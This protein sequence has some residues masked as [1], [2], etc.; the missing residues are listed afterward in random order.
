MI[1]EIIKV[2]SIDN[3]FISEELIK[4]LGG[5]ET[6]MDQVVKEHLYCPASILDDMEGEKEFANAIAELSVLD[7]LLNSAGCVYFRIIY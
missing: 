6:Y 1:G 5:R 7:N 4:T 3:Q 2:A